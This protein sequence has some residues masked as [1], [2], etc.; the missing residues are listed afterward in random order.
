[1]GPREKEEG[2]L[3]LREVVVFVDPG[4]ALEEAVDEE[5]EMEEGELVGGDKE[6]E[7]GGS[8]GS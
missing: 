6:K 7:V 1:M 4:F 8:A 3:F 2:R 5:E